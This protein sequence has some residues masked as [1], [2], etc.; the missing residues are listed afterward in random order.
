MKNQA[1][2][3]RTVSKRFGRQLVLDNLD[4]DLHPGHAVALT[5]EN[6]SGK[7][8]L[9]R[10]A[11]GLLKPEDG[12]V[13]FGYGLLRWRRARREL[14]A[15]VM[16]LHQSPY[17]FRGSVTRNLRLA[18]PPA[19]GPALRRD[20]VQHALEWAG[21]QSHADKD[22][23]SL[24]GGQQQRVALARAWL[25]KPQFLLLDEP[26]ANMDTQSSLRTINLLSQLKLAGMGLVICTHQVQV[27]DD[28]ADSHLVLAS[29][30]LSEPSYDDPTNNVTSIVRDRRRRP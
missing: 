29:G 5:G 10:I 17:M 30:R 28:L 6:G 2:S 3:L 15:R 12:Y 8:T 14:L 27:F 20:L 19:T 26:I 1:I 9:M 18:L 11:A 22:A 23:I 16:Y 4:F 25:R 21:L 24:S 7:T 13:D